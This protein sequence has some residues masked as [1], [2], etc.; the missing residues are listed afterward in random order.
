MTTSATRGT[1]SGRRPTMTR[2]LDVLV[3]IETNLD[4][5]LSLDALAARAEMSPFHF[6]RTFRE[7]IGETPRAHVERVRLER[8]ALQLV[9]REASILDLALEHGFRSHEVFTRAFR[10]RFGTSPTQ[11]RVEWP[12][13]RAASTRA[14]GLEQ[15]IAA[16]VLSST[17]VHDLRAA[18][19]AFIRHIGP[20]EDVDMSAW[21]TLSSWAARRGIG[22]GALLGVAHDAPNLVAPSRLRFDACIV[23]PDDAPAPRSGSRIALASLTEGPHAVTT[24]VGP[25][26]Q[27]G[28][29]YRTI[30]TRL[31]ARKDVRVIGLPAIERYVTTELIEGAI[32]KI[33]IALPVE[34]RVR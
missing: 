9:L 21:R 10:R 12:A 31:L 17:K 1:R 22:G 13:R 16:S 30:M 33:E 18:R 14:P 2:F 11:W 24:F 34:R 7:E 8:A 15:E 5:E 28:D 20:Y 27:L 23:V 6:Q 25:L 4:D 32:Q 19:V 3:H 29:A 26:A